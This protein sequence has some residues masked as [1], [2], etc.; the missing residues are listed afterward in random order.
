MK[1]IVF[2]LDNTLCKIGK[3]ILPTTAQMLKTLEEKG[4]RKLDEEG[5]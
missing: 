3:E 1:C 4:N 2:D 5:E